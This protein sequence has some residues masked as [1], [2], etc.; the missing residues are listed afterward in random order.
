[1][2][3]QNTARDWAMYHPTTHVG[4][5]HAVIHRAMYYW[6]AM[7]ALGV[8]YMSNWRYER[9]N[10]K[11]RPTA[12]VA[13]VWHIVMIV[14]VDAR[15]CLSLQQSYLSDV[16]IWRPWHAHGQVQVGLSVNVILII[17]Q[18]H[19]TRN[20]SATADIQS[21]KEKINDSMWR[22]ETSADSTQNR[23]MPQSVWKSN[24]S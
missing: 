20:G 21:A 1:M 12:S 18:L 16:W 10:D 3:R 15:C 19:M 22:Q 2:L 13:A 9:H 11:N 24:Y 5:Q 17:H 23:T 7:K 14:C 6:Y 8:A 4:W